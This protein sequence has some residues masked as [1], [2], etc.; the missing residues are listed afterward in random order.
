MQVDLAISSWTVH[1]ALGKV[2]Y[3]PDDNGVMVNKSDDHPAL[4]TLL[5]L[6]AHMAKDGIYVLELC[7]FHLPSIDDDYLVQLKSALE[8]AG[9]TLANLLIDTGNLSELDDKKWRADLNMTKRWQDVAAKL[10][11]KGTRIDCGTEPATQETIKRSAEALRELVEYGNSIGLHTTT[12]NWRATSIEP[13][14]L[15]EIMKQVDR[16]MKLCVDFGNAEK[17]ADKYATLERLMPRANSIHCKG[18]FEG[19]TLDED[20]FS[21]SLDFIKKYD[22]SGH[23]SLIDD[24]TEN[25]WD[26]VLILKK[27]VEKQ[28]L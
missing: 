11:A 4:L 26:R 8:S 28:L 14:N 3:E 19:M 25:E 27:Q 5:D 24:G 9:V 6:P 20:E 2:W 21:Q 17:T 15:F 7:N 22:F 10:G 1:G 16:P 13:D 18:H 12:E 23:I